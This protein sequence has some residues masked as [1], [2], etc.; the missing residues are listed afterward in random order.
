MRPSNAYGE[1]QKP[2]AGQGFIATAIVSILKDQEIT[3]YGDQGTVRDY[4]HVSDVVRGIVAALDQGFAGSC[5]NIGT[6][7]G[8]NNREV[9]DIILPFARTLG[10][11]P[12][13]RVAA[14]T[15]IRC[16]RQR[17]RFF[18]NGNEKQGGDLASPLMK[19][20]K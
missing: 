6:G 14:H 9:M 18:K 11:E 10:L 12:K 3:I 19:G 16:S 7:E 15:G 13:I 1:R 20:S 4:I 8:R 2:F 17:A 5:Y